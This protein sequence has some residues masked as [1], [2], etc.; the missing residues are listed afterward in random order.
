MSF[1]QEKINPP[2]YDGGKTVT[3]RLVKALRLK[4]FKE[5]T[6]VL[7]VGKG[8]IS[9]WHQ[10]EQTPFE[11]VVRVH[12]KTGVS[13]KWLLLGEGE[14]YEN[15]PSRQL[16]A[17]KDTDETPTKKI[18][19]FIL[20]GGELHKQEPL[21][22]DLRFIAQLP[23]HEDLAVVLDSGKQIY[24]DKADTKVIAGKFLVSYAGITTVSELHKLPNGSVFM[25]LNGRDVEV[26]PE[27]IKPQGRVIF[28]VKM[29]N[30]K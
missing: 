19:Y 25:V 27:H 4:E 6:E 29:D 28:Q 24:V 1:S 10:R 23:E 14:M 8:T 21:T 26:D 20:K 7:G 12:L 17:S 5:L 18:P 22:L 16:T 15:G 9:T 11:V 13:L 2:M 30:A 3:S